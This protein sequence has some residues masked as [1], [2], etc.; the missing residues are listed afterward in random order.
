MGRIVL[1]KRATVNSEDLR[2]VFISGLNT[3]SGSGT[4]ASPYASANVVATNASGS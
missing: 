4:D 1:G 3:S 2:G